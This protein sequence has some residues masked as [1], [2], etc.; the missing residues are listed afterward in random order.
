M[1]SLDDNAISVL[2]RLGEDISDAALEERR[3]T[4]TPLDLA[5]LIYT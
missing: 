5:T 2:V 4:A 1:W 3:T